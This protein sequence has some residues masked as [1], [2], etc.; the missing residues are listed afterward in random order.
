MKL[1]ALVALPED[2]ISEEYIGV[3]VDDLSVTPPTGLKRIGLIYKVDDRTELDEDLLDVIISYRLADIDALLEIP[4]D[5]PVPDARYLVQVAANAGFSLS[6]LP[7]PADADE[8][9]KDAYVQRLVT[10]TDVYMSQQN[11]SA[12]LHP[13]SSFLEYMFA[14]QIADIQAMTPSDPYIRQRFVDVMPTALVDHFKNAVKERVFA[15]YDGEEGF[16]A[17]AKA[18]V[19]KVYQQTREIAADVAKDMGQPG[20]GGDQPSAGDPQPEPA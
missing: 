12:F 9:T 13:L 3:E 16:R 17:F 2:Q 20:E 19:Y 11:F 1:S 6:L 8:A 4:H 10:F 7:P 15:L 5:A 14:E 18:V